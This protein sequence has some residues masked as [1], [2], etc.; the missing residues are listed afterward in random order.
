MSAKESRRRIC[1]HIWLSS[2]KSG[3]LEQ[4]WSKPR[5]Y[6]NQP[7][8]FDHICSNVPLFFEDSHICMH[9]LL[10]LSF[11]DI[12]YVLLLFFCWNTGTFINIKLEN[13]LP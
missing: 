1:I 7:L 6:T 13:Q 8:G 3:T 5:V 2:K 12:S 9:I 10:L 11:A 4:M